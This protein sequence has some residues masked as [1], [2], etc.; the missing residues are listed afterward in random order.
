[1]TT[2]T[3]NI[4]VQVP[5]GYQLD[6]LTE[7]LTKYAQHLIAIRMN[8]QTV[9]KHYKHETLCGIFSSHASEEELIE[10]YLKDKY[11]V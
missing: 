9:K 5:K 3:L 2:A 7:Q 6:V 4:P 8:Q 11:N 10:E 1:M